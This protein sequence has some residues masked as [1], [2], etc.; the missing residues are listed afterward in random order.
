NNILGGPGMNSRLNISLR[1]KSGYSYNV[2]SHYTSYSD[3]G[4]L[5]IYF[6]CDK[7][8]FDKSLKLVF[9]EFQRLKTEAMG[10]LQLR[11]AKNQL[12]GQIAIANDSNEYEMLR[13]GKS[14]LLYN[15]VN[16]LKETA[17]KIEALTSENLLEVANEILDKNQTSILQYY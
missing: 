11:K 4:I 7:E 3:T 1:E 5:N 14:T 9:K 6:G 17:A 2:E 13:M 16:G 8:N 15:R 10:S 12:L